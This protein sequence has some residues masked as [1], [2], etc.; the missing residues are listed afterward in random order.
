MPGKEEYERLI[1]ESPLF[2]IDKE[3]EPSAYS[4]ES[5]KMVEYL[6]NYLMLV[7]G[8]TNRPYGL[9]IVNTARDCIKCYTPSDGEFIHYFNKAWMIN[10]KRYEPEEWIQ[11]EYMDMKF[12]ESQKRMYRKYKKTCSILGIDRTYPEFMNL[13]GENMGISVEELREIMI[14]EDSKIEWYDDGWE[15]DSEEPQKQYASDLNLIAEVE[16]EV[17]NERRVFLDHIEAEYLKVQVR[18]RKMFAMV[19]TA[20]LAL[21]V[22]DKDID[23]FR[24]KEFFDPSIYEEC[25]KNQKPVTQKEIAARLGILEPSLSRAW[26]KFK[27][28]L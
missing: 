24:G 10:R 11:T 27:E 25:I 17:I 12:T 22:D 18:Q 13:V 28:K 8:K 1:N 7:S 3:R 23:Y 5:L 14:M 19:I 16:A 4:R 9:E 26:S 2:T 6:Y 15:L 20:T 21:S